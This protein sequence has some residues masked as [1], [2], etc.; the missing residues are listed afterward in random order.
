M[1]AS[2][3][4]EAAKI[5]SKAQR[6]AKLNLRH[7]ATAIQ[8]KSLATFFRFIKWSCIGYHHPTFLNLTIGFGLG[9]L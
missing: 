9:L 7:L 2:P 6:K 1:L 8:V 5:Q 3:K 4:S